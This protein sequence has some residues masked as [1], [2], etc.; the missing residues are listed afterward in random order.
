MNKN[1]TVSDL[2]N[3][4]ILSNNE[5]KWLRYNQ[6]VTNIIGITPKYICVGQPDMTKKKEK[7]L[8][9]ERFSTNY[10]TREEFEN[11][12]STIIDYLM[13]EEYAPEDLVNKVGE[14]VKELD[15]QFGE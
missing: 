2:E 6:R 7:R 13:R 15:L 4:K 8:S 10:K 9:A 5:V 14:T 1:V 3:N 11:D 12:R